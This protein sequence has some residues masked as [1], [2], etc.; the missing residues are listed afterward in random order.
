VW[1]GHGVYVQEVFIDAFAGLRTTCLPLSLP[2]IFL[3]KVIY[4]EKWRTPSFRFNKHKGVTYII[5]AA[6]YRVYK[7]I[8][9]S[10]RHESCLVTWRSTKPFWIVI[11]FIR[12]AAAG[13]YTAPAVVFLGEDRVDAF[14]D[15]ISPGAELRLL[16]L[17]RLCKFL[18][19]PRCLSSLLSLLL[20][21][22]Y[23]SLHLR[24]T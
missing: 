10:I 21:T 11:R 7:A 16:I 22:S 1:R 4:K 8:E 3:A 14:G 9:F 13:I 2:L 17:G 6:V 15:S 23:F 19:L 18:H 24:P 5:N 20:H 12:G